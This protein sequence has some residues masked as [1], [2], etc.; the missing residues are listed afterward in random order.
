MKKTLSRIVAFM[1]M[2]VMAVSVV[3]L[4]QWITL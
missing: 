1:L 4:K 2:I 3:N